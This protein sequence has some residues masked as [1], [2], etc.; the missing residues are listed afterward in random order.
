MIENIGY[1]E[2]LIKLCDENHFNLDISY[3]PNPDEFEITIKEITGFEYYY[4]RASDFKEE[5]EHIVVAYDEYLKKF[6]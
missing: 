3:T 4:K 1:L 6:R 5:F 2:N